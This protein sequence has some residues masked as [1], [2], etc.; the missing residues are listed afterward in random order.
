MSESVSSNSGSCI[1]ATHLSIYA[2]LANDV[3]VSRV[4]YPSIEPGM[5]FKKGSR[6]ML[7]SFPRDEL[8]D[9]DF[10][11]FYSNENKLYGAC[12]PEDICDFQTVIDSYITLRKHGAFPFDDEASIASEKVPCTIF[13]SLSAASSETDENDSPV[14]VKEVDVHRAQSIAS[15]L[16]AEM[17][18][19]YNQNPEFARAGNETV[20]DADDLADMMSTTNMR[21]D[22]TAANNRTS[23]APVTSTPA[24]NRQPSIQGLS[25][26]RHV[27][28]STMLGREDLMRM[29]ESKQVEAAVN[30]GIVPVATGM[31]EYA[32]RTD[33]NIKQIGDLLKNQMN[34]ASSQDQ[35][36]GNLQTQLSSLA[37]S[38][39]TNQLAQTIIANVGQHFAATIDAKFS[40]LKQTVDPAPIMNTA[41]DPPAE[42][43]KKPITKAKKGR[44]SARFTLP[45]SDTDSDSEIAELIHNRTFDPQSSKMYCADAMF[46]DNS[47]LAEDSLKSAENAMKRIRS[48]PEMVPKW[49]RSKGGLLSIF[50]CKDVFNFARKQ[51][52]LNEKFLM[53][54][55]SY[56]FPSDNEE[57]VYMYLNE[58]RT[59]FPNENLYKT[60]RALAFRMRPSEKTS[61]DALPK[62]KQNEGLLDLVLRLKVDIPICA[63]LKKHEITNKIVEF[64]RTHEQ[65][66]TVKLEFKK[67]AM[68]YGR[69]ITEKQLL[70]I[71]ENIDELLETTSGHQTTRYQQVTQKPDLPSDRKALEM[72]LDNQQSLCDKIAALEQSRTNPG[73]NDNPTKCHKCQAQAQPRK[74]GGFYPHCSQCF[75]TKVQIQK[76]TIYKSSPARPI[77][78]VCQRN[79]CNIGRSG[80]P[81]STCFDCASRSEFGNM[82]KWSDVAKNS[83]NKQVFRNESTQQG[84]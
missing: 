47:A 65:D 35:A 3:Q 23:L 28:D 74:N 15:D 10:I 81:F 27:A 61:I 54:W 66:P 76:P 18:A 26:K 16:D 11:R 21:L 13:D 44:R 57:K 5:V 43:Q 42:T 77:C 22:D 1:A 72:L 37:N 71:A 64:I 50:L 2:F 79:T 46:A 6:V 9:I 75:R 12:E 83:S 59:L 53:F 7:T 41:V 52:L 56:V 68:V 48:N 55:I 17:E 19:F 70:K 49:N 32:L 78:T 60:L 34:R 33:N 30:Q 14:T 38:L 4:D 82:R 36:I 25:S 58:I 31:Q 84:N 29:Q 39:D 40:E 63:D 45:D 20:L 24:P 67:S 80:K 51:G 73:R 62:R 8:D 69:K